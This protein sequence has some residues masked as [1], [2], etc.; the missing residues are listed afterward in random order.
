ME[1]RI[2][3]INCRIRKLQSIV[4]YSR[5]PYHRFYYETQLKKSLNEFH[6]LKMKAMNRQDRV[7]TLEELSNYDGSN[8][9][10]AY[11]AVNGVVYDV[12]LEPTWGGGTHSGLVAGKDY[13]KEFNE[14][15]GGNLKILEKLP[16]VGIL[17]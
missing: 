15:H 8:G 5:C 6:N 7:F 17:K 13:T 10:P 4:F 16:K 11:I 1:N 12:S 14:C 2:Y 3:K 9:K